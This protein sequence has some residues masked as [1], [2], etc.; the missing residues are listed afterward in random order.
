M[1]ETARK[2]I[3][4]FGKGIFSIWGNILMSRNIINTRSRRVCL[5]SITSSQHFSKVSNTAAFMLGQEVTSI[6]AN[7]KWWRVLPWSRN[8]N[9]FLI[10]MLY[11]SSQRVWYLRSLIFW[12]IVPWPRILILNGVRQ[13]PSQ[14]HLIPTFSKRE[15]SL[16]LFILDQVIAIRWWRIGQLFGKV[17]LAPIPKPCGACR[18]CIFGFI[19]SIASLWYSC[20]SSFFR[21]RKRYC[22]GKE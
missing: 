3:S 17:I 2:T 16:C 15:T 1:P 11:P 8:C 12:L 22:L 19:E 9:L 6:S 18:L 7:R 13:R 20:Y 10:L 14:H 21:L 5:D 4:A